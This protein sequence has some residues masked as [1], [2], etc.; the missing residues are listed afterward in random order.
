MVATPQA[1]AEDASLRL[2]VTNLLDAARPVETVDVAASAL[3]ARWRA[4]DL[5]ALAVTDARTGRQVLAQAVDEDGDGSFDRLVFQADFAPREAR[6][7]L[8]SRA[9]PRKARLEDYRVYGRFVRERHDDFAWE[10]DRVAFRVYGEALETFAE[11]PLTSSAVD[12]WA[13]RTR[14]LVINDWY[15]VDDY[16]REHGEGGDFYPAGRTRGC[17]GSGLVVDGSLAVSRNFRSSR[18]LAPGPIRLV[19]EVVYPEWERPGLKATEVK[20]VT[21]DAGRHFNR[22]DSFYRTEG[23]GPVT[24]AAG[25]RKA[26]GAALHVDPE[27]GLVRTWEHLDRYG[28]NGWLGCGLVLD[29][30]TVVGT[31]EQG[32]SQLL[33]ARTPRGQPATF[34]AGFGWDGDGDFPDVAAW[35]LYL[36]AFAARVRSP[37]AVEVVR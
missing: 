35:D 9:E 19:F 23:D 14:R 16:H 28:Q 4:S 30:A 33:V 6:E 25:I 2:R 29:P 21:L 32:G 12:V 13:K 22:F 15:L 31:M 1:V 24:W 3:A 36:E 10:N 8:L 18:V 34:Y 5:P 27:R 20:R 26:E 17:G 11:E 37:L 7:F